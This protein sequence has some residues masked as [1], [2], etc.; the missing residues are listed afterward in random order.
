VS[1]PEIRFALTRAR[2]VRLR[3]VRTTGM[4]M[5]HEFELYER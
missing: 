4:P 3:L 5:I 1:H 2:Y